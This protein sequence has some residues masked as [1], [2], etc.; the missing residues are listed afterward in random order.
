MKNN[1]EKKSAAETD[2][3]QT[4]IILNY[5]FSR[6]DIRTGLINARRIRKLA[7]INAINFNV[8]LLFNDTP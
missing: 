5:S 1:I 4:E 8:K 3:Q 2:Q 7:E 6:K